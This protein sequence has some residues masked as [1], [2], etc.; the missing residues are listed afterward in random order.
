MIK[1]FK[2]KKNTVGITFGSIFGLTLTNTKQVPNYP[3]FEYTQTSFIGKYYS[4]KSPLYN[5]K[6]ISIYYLSLLKLLIISNSSK[7]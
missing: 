1:L 4:K 6:E 5:N 7:D 2:T 3:S